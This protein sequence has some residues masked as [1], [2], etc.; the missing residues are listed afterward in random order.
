MHNKCRG[1][2][3]IVMQAGWSNK[4]TRHHEPVDTRITKVWRCKTADASTRL[5]QFNWQ[6]IDSSAWDGRLL[7]YYQ[8]YTRYNEIAPKLCYYNLSINHLNYTGNG[9]R[10]IRNCKTYESLIYSF[11]VSK[12]VTKHLQGENPFINCYYGVMICI[13]IK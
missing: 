8:C 13:D 1:V 6:I 4:S 2:G 10:G 5:F 12:K 3:V 11:L 7:N 9:I